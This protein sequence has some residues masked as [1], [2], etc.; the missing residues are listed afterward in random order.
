MPV[1]PDDNDHPIKRWRLTQKP[2]VTL[3]CL[4]AMIGTGKSN[5][6]KLENGLIDPRLDTV[7]R[8]VEATGAEV[9]AEMIIFWSRNH[10]KRKAA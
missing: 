8:L 10:R 7:G 1:G 9:T 4:A 3:D 6:S 5:L 2:P